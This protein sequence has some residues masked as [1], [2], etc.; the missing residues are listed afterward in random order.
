MK[1]INCKVLNKQDKILV[2]I[3]KDVPV[4]ETS[5]IHRYMQKEFPDNKII[6]IHN[7]F[8]DGI[9]ILKERTE[10]DELLQPFEDRL[11]S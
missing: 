11:N 5:S 10:F 1:N 8:I 2:Y 6:I 4:D 9:D 3:N 7:L